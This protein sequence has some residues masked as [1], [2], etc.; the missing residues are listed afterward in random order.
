MSG[1]DPERWLC[2]FVG[3]AWRAPFSV[4]LATVRAANGVELG[5]VVLADA[6]DM[7][8]AARLRRAASRQ[9][10]LCY[11]SC[12]ADL[13]PAMFCGAL[14]PPNLASGAIYLAHPQDAAL[15]IALADRI[16]RAGLT[17]GA[18]ALLFQM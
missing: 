4:H 11:R 9:D 18:F 1:T 8:R 17:P 13:D 5:Q 15:A 14:P 6:T 2:Q 3:G 10:E 16:A 7:E 12:V